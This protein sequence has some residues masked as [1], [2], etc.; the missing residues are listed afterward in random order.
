MKYRVSQSAHLH[1]LAD[2]G[3]GTVHRAEYLLQCIGNDAD[4]IGISQGLHQVGPTNAHMGTETF[5]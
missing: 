3:Q 5:S 4:S 1:E 2:Y